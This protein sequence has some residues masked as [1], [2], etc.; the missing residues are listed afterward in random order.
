M[1]NKKLKV[2]F[3]IEKRKV[4]S[5]F[6]VILI[7]NMKE[8]FFRQ[9]K[10]HLPIIFKLIILSIVSS[11]ESNYEINIEDH[12]L[13]VMKLMIEERHLWSPDSGLYI[14]GNNG[15]AIEGCN[16]IAN[17]NQRWE[18]PAVVSYRENDQIIFTDSVGFRIKGKCSRSN[19]MKSIGLYWRAEYG[20]NRI[21]YDL[22]PGLGIYKFKRLML[23]NSGNDFGRTHIKDAAISQIIKDYANVEYQEY[24]PVVVYLNDEYWGIH[25]LR[26]LITP[27]HFKY[28]YGVNDER[29]DLLEGSYLDPVAD[30]G[31]IDDFVTEITE[32][33]MNNDLSIDLNYA[34]ISD[35]I[36]IASLIDFHIIETYI[37]NRDWPGN[38]T[39]WWREKFSP[40]FNKWRWILFDT[41]FSF[42]LDNLN[43]V[44]IGNL[45][46]NVHYENKEDGFFLFN[47]L[48]RNDQFR[49]EFLARYMFFLETVFN[50]VR[51]AEII[52]GIKENINN[53]YPN[54]QEKWNTMP[55]KSWNGAI[56]DLKTFNRKRNIK[57]KKIIEEL[58]N[59]E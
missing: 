58:I 9:P 21:E 33:V 55:Y 16:T 4:T 25:N 42:E 47:E 29:V 15:I 1:G 32:Y 12:D 31:S 39:K 38:N 30:D 6:F 22:F 40:D 2:S 45:Y 44:W 20:K 51:V 17:Y 24:Q 52:D 23:R 57:M 35:R 37:Y 8:I 5:L 14:V 50:P 49:N 53:E 13:P 10:Q 46:G 56:S 43:K 19:S 34:I 54:H 3:I 48:I 26:E 27:H 36:D 41:D 28:H 18:F 11:C 59:E 7:P